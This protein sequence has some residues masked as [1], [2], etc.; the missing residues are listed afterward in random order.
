VWK[1]LNHPNIVPFKGVRLDPPQLI[2]EWMPN[3][4]LRAYIKRNRGANLI[5]LVS[6]F[7][8]VPTYLT[9]HSLLSC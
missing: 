9:S 8:L 2:S 5:G 3:G 6:S 4:E 1:R 7:P